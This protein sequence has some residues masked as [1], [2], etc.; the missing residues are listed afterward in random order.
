MSYH[1]FNHLK[2]WLNG[3]IF[4]KIG[5]GIFSKYLTDIE[6]NCSLSSKVNRI[7]VYEGKWRSEYT[8]YEVKWSICDDIYISNTQQTFK[9]R[10]DVHLSDLLRLFKNGKNQTHLLPTLNITLGLLRHVQIYVSIWRSK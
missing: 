3:E 7:C 5:Q 8:I 10:M 4:V 2:E 9:T 6:C 1:R